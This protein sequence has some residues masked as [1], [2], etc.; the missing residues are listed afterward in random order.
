M[1]AFVITLLNNPD[2]VRMAKRCKDSANIKVKTFEAVSRDT[3]PDWMDSLN[4]EW[5]WGD[6]YGGMKHKPYGGDHWARVG[7]FLSHYLLWWRCSRLDTPIMILEHD[8]VFVRNFHPF[9]FQSIC[10]IND[11]FMA[12]PRGDWWSDQMRKRGPGVW[13][14]TRVFED[15]R[16]DGLAG[17]SAYLIKP[18][19][20][21][22]LI[23]LVQVLG[24]WPNDALICRQLVRGLEEVYPFITHVESDIS[25]IQGK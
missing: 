24:A 8:A 20:A 1:E 19:A 16:P 7:C 12:T 22:K 18:E 10:M 9:E 2:S 21:R 5:T 23:N 15:D 13:P 11:P 4:L 14:K 17:N 25:T 6:G 3:A